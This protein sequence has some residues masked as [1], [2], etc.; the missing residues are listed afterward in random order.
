M[1]LMFAT[2]SEMMASSLFVAGF[3]GFSRNKEFGPLFV[4]VVAEKDG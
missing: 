1:H 3:S 2:G 4:P